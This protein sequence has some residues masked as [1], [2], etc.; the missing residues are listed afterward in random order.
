MSYPS[1][2]ENSC[3]DTCMPLTQSVLMALCSG[4]AEDLQSLIMTVLCQRFSFPK[5]VEAKRHPLIKDF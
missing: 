3:F 4:G 1:S 5:N 2:V